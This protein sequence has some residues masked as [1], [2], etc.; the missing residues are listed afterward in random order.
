M[1]ECACPS[2]YGLLMTP[3]RWAE[4]TTQGTIVL[5]ATCGSCGGKKTRLGEFLPSEII[6]V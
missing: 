2:G 4:W 1:T 3:G 6:A 5:Y